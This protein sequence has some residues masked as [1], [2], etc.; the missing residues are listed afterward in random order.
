MHK[1]KFFVKQ[2]IADEAIIS[3][4]HRSSKTIFNLITAAGLL[5]TI[6]DVGPFYPKFI[7]EFIVNLPVDL[8]DHGS[9]EYQKVHVQ[10][11]CF[12]ILPALIN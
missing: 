7:R 4:Q 11:N 10:S 9:P 5:P 1:W 8:N 12:E 3:N 6:T 2:W